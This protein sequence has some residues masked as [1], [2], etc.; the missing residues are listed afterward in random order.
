MSGPFLLLYQGL[1][2][3]HPFYTHTHTHT[4]TPLGVLTGCSLYMEPSLLGYCSACSLT[5]SHVTFLMRAIL[6]A[7]NI[8]YSYLCFFSFCNL[9]AYH[10]MCLLITLQHLWPPLTVPPQPQ[11]RPP[12][13]P[14]MWI[15]Q[16]REFPS[17]L[18]PD[19]S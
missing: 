18:F 5:S 14:S 16:R 6:N 11:A 8:L 2:H 3:L 10:T 1:F 15:P 17:V 12:T 13:F 9:T 7:L 4:H 19:T